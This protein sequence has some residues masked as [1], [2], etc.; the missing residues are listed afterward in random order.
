MDWGEPPTLPL[1]P[2][3]VKQVFETVREINAHGITVLLVEQNVF[4][5]LSIANQAYVL[6]N[7]RVVLGGPGK[8]VLDNPQVREAYLGI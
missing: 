3:L 6:E 7:G 1:A 5:S 4:H 8:E 2:M